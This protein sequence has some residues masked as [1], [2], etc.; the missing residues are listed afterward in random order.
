[1]LNL[2]L[3]WSSEICTGQPAWIDRSRWITQP[4]QLG[5]CLMTLDFGCRNEIDTPNASMAS[6]EKLSSTDCLIS[7]FLRMRELDDVLH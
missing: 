4:V 2:V 5:N 6:I 3:H 7:F 1:L